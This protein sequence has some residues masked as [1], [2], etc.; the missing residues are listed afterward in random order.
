MSA[1]IFVWKAAGGSGVNQGLRA[2]PLA[3][4]TGGPASVLLANI[5]SNLY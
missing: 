2:A 4:T 3:A 5:L 1:W